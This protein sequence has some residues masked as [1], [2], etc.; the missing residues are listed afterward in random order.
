MSSHT[1][2]VLETRLTGDNNESPSFFFFTYHIFTFLV[3]PFSFFSKRGNNAAT[4]FHPFRKEIHVEI[5]FH[6]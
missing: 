4:E 2:S 5:Q 3:N 1:I 6:R